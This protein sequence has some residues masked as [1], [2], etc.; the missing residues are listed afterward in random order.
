MIMNKK[1]VSALIATVLLIGITVVAAGVI[2]VVVNSMTKTIKTT[3]ACQDAAGLSLNT[4]EEYKSC[5]L[6]F[7]N[8]GVKNYYVFLQLGR[9]EKSYELNAIQVHLSYAGS[10]STVEIKPNA[11]NVYNPT[12]RNIPI[13]LPNANG[14]ESYLIDAS[15][16]GINYPVSRVGIA[17]IITVGT[18]LETCK[19]YYEVDLPKC[20]PS[21][22]FT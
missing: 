1:A 9:D 19:V 20:A 11:S 13:R 6:E 8:N 21:F 5:L 12:D 10:S 22:T 7:D 4:D 3:Q 15:A 17:P 16:S 14:D 2:F 18:T